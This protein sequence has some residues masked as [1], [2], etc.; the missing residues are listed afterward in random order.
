MLPRCG[1]VVRNLKNGEEWLVAWAHGNYLA[2][3]GWPNGIARLSDCEV[4]TRCTDEDHAKA[5][6]EWLDRDHRGDGNGGQD[7]RVGMVRRLYRP[8]EQRR[9]DRE[10]LNQDALMVA[11]RIAAHDRNLADALCRF[12]AGVP[13]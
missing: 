8:E 7:S 2:P 12:A 11:D 6:S 13:S 3:W 1:D 9:L 10:R 5:V 4:V